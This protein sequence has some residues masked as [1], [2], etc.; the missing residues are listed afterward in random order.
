MNQR[1][2]GRYEI[3]TLAGERVKAFIPLPLPPNPPIQWSSI[4]M[5]RQQRAAMALGRLDAISLLLPE[6][7]T[8]P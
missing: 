2:T 1:K 4:L 3:T 7:P 8:V 6:Q 5:D